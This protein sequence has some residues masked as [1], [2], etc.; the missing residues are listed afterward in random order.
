MCCLMFDEIYLR[1]QISWSYQQ[2][3]YVGYANINGNEQSNPKTPKTEKDDVAKQAIVFL[4]NGIDVNLELPLAYYFINELPAKDRK[5]LIIEII[6]MVSRCGVK[7]T[8]LTFDGLASNVPACEMLGANL[9]VDHDEFKPYIEDPIT[10]EKI[11]IFLD[12]CH[13]EKLVRNRWSICKVFFFYTILFISGYVFSSR[14][15]CKIYKMYTKNI[16]SRII[17]FYIQDIYL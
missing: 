8:N 7:I 1:Q 17:F 5:K 2:F 3:R 16:H 4:L 10:K 12:P 14:K 11:Y 9:K 15:F 6:A 13:I